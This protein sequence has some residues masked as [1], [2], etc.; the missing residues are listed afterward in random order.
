M[1]LK[2]EITSNLELYAILLFPNK[3]LV[4]FETN[5]IQEVVAFGYTDGR[6]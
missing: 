6:F 5:N 3:R 2:F 4:S 1:F